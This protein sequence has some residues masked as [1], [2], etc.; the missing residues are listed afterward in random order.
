MLT[1]TWCG[2][3]HNGGRRGDSWSQSE[4]W[5]RLGLA[6]VGQNGHFLPEVTAAKMTLKCKSYHVTPY[7]KSIQGN[8]KTCNSQQPP[9]INAHWSPGR[10]PCVMA[11]V[12][13]SLSLTPSAPFRCIV[14]NG[15]WHP[16][17]L[18][19]ALLLAGL[20]RSHSSSL[21]SN[22]I[23]DKYLEGVLPVIPHPSSLSIFFTGLTYHTRSLRYCSVWL[24]LV[25]CSFK[26]N[27]E[28]VHLSP[29]C[30]WSVATVPG[31]WL[32]LICA[33]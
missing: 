28:H 26:E 23:S 11:P 24:T 9:G 1:I 33:K 19:L 16:G 18:R 2:S 3:P 22:S 31:L 8:Q 21:N 27:G 12:P 14:S 6:I 25:D 4:R 32:D 29:Q 5:E 13:L 17:L 15:S 30:G 10:G 7:L 20:A